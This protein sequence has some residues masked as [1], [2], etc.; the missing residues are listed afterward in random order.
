MAKI[1]LLE[2][3]PIILA[4]VAIIFSSLKMRKV[5]RLSDMIYCIVSAVSAILL[6]IAQTSWWNS[7]VIEKNLIGTWLSN[8]IWLV[9]NTLAMI[10]IILQTYP[11]ADGK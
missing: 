8:Q 10:A 9:F 11:R 3:V 5:R 6:I 2:F 4:V 1:E 7:A